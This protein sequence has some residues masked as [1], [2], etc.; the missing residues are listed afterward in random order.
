MKKTIK[1]EEVNQKELS[2]RRIEN[3]KAD[4][5]EMMKEVKP[6]IKKSKIVLTSTEGKWFDT[7]DTGDNI[8]CIDSVYK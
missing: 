8:I 6:F 7:T 5:E 1:K 4:F 2:A 3:A